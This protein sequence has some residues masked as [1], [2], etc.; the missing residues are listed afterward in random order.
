MSD[1]T[2]STAVFNDDV[3][4]TLTAMDSS[5]TVD[6]SDVGDERV[7][8]VVQNNNDSA[9]VNTA[10]ITIAPGGFLSS[11]LGTLSVDVADGGAVKVIGPLEGC[12]FK[13]TGS[14][15]TIGCSV[16]QSGTVSDVNLGV[17]KLP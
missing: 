10:S 14:K 17:I 6:V 4:L 5:V 16:T 3:A 1:Y 8:L 11:V 12:R 9:A 7:L 13:S 2:A 15:L